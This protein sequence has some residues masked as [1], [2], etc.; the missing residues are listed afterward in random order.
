MEKL[1]SV[2]PE[3]LKQKISESTTDDLHSTS[4]S[5]L[6]FFQ[7]L[8]LFHQMVRDLT[9]PEMALCGKNK[10]AAL[11]AKAKGNECFSKGDYSSA[12]HFYSQVEKGTIL[13]SY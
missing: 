3:P 6:H 4:S 10:E 8:P 5:L 1:K 11:E 13:V 12:L 7:A 2:I 9:D